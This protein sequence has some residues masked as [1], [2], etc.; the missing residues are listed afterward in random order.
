MN[1]PYD[2]FLYSLGFKIS[3]VVKN[4]TAYTIIP[5]KEDITIIITGNIFFLAKYL[6]STDIIPKTAVIIIALKFI[7]TASSIKQF[8]PII[9]TPIAKTI[10]ITQGFNPF[11]TACTYLFLTAFFNSAVIKSII[12]KEGKTTAS[13]AIKAD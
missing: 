4:H 8:L 12:M 7:L 2:I 3:P 1:S 10:P 9:Y 5:N 6:Y 13:V 11:K